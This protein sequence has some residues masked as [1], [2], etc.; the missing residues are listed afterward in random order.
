M[1]NNPSFSE[2]YG[3]QKEPKP[4]AIRHE[5]PLRLRKAILDIAIEA[6]FKAKDIRGILC[7][8]LREIENEDNWSDDPVM[9]ECLN[10]I[11]GC[12]WVEV[13]EICEVLAQ[14][15]N[16]PLVW[17]NSFEK[18]LNKFFVEEGIGWKIENGLIFTRGEEDF[19]K[20]MS[21]AKDRLEKTKRMTAK[22][23]LEEA[24]KNL[25]RRPEPNTTGAIN[26]SMVALECV[27]KEI[28]QEPT[29]T[30]GKI[31]NKLNLPKPI[32]VVVEKIW[33]FASNQGRHITEGKKPDFAE[34]ELTVHLSAA[35][36]S[37]LCEKN[38]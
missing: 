32:D 11:S 20:V 5:A 33:G 13:Y 24:I 22:S 3:Y 27:A 34:A 6:G 36:I 23:E 31:I 4:I 17:R 26:H 14:E 15:K 7:R 35:L 1:Q 16:I 29:K 19:E 18:G 38:K 2:R 30:L 8:K 25:S 37:Y 28:T 9:K 10:L 21:I 12:E